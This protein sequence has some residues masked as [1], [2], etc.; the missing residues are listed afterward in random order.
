MIVWIVLKVFAADEGGLKADLTE[1]GVRG[2]IKVAL[3][4]FKVL[5][6]HSEVQLAV[7]ARI[8]A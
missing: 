3:F 5:R 1:K 6:L 2:P 7:L 8:I 4:A